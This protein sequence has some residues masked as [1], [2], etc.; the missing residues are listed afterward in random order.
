[1]KCIPIHGKRLEF[2]LF[3][4]LSNPSYSAILPGEI[5]NKPN[6]NLWVRLKEQTDKGGIMDVDHLIRK[7][8]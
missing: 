3:K 2:D 7:S 4:V 8:K 6:E 1:M 5:D